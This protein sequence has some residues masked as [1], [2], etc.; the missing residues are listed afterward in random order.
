VPDIFSIVIGSTLILGGLLLV[1]IGV[2]RYVGKTSSQRHNY[3]LLA[4]FIFVQI[5]F[6]YVQPSLLIRKLNISVGLLLVCS[7]Y[8]WLI[9]RL[10][11]AEMRKATKMFGII[12]AT[13]SLVSV[14][15]IFVD[16]SAPQ[17]SNLFQSSF[18]DTLV[19]LTYQM[20]IIAV[21]FALFL[22][23]NRR[24]VVELEIDIIQRKR[25]EDE[26]RE[27][28]LRD[29]LTDLYNRR[30]FITMVEQQLKA[31]NRA[32][33]SMMLVF[34]D[35]DGMKWINDTLGHEDGDKALIG[36]ADILKETFRESDIIAR[37]GGDEFAVLAIDM[38]DLNPEVLS[39]RLGQNMDD[40]N[41]NKARPYKVAISWGTAIYNPESPM[42]LDQLISSAD[43]LM[44]EQKK[45]RKGNA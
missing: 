40:W 12:M 18:Y 35:V 31:A 17:G 1:G 10:T 30:G 41:A 42:S 15:R 23:V 7:Q 4:V 5:Y 9:L 44:Y 2:K 26:I 8:A 14:V 38:T 27:M 37:M 34:L 3:I 20:L 45:A 24:L 43:T 6:T 21:T 29:Q 36:T 19:I 32:K 13:F 25:A 39:K 33:S 16:L 22:M 28:S 11:D